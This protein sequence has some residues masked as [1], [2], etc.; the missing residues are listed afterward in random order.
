MRF[1][2]TDD[3]HD[4]MA[5]GTAVAVGF[6]ARYDALIAGGAGA[7]VV[8]GLALTRGG[9]RGR[10]ASLQWGRAATDA[11]V[12]LFP[13][14]VVAVVW[15]FTS[16]LITGT[17]FTQFSGAY[18][19]A[20]IIESVGGGATG[21]APE[22]LARILLLAP[23]LPVLVVTV[24]VLARR[25]RAPGLWPP[26]MLLGSVLAFQVVS[27][28]SGTTFGLLRFFIVAV[29]MAAVL[30]LLVPF[31]SGDVSS[32][33]PGRHPWSGGTQRPLYRPR[34]SALASLVLVVLGTTSTTVAMTEQRWA[35]QEYAL[36]A[37]TPLASGM[38][39]DDLAERRS[40]LRTFGVERRLAS[41]LDTRDLASG[42][43]LLDVTYGFPVPL[44][45]A[46]PDT[47]VVPSDPDFETS[48][49]D[50]YAH[51]VRYILAVPP[52]GRGLQDAVNRRYPTFYDNGAGV[53]TLDMEIANDGSGQPDF[54]L[55]RVRADP[56]A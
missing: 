16:W 46:A 34:T 24:L 18:G 20:A 27:A 17:A 22:A 51:G 6:L 14:S 5:A 13:V 45:S 11:V 49:D 2:R 15:F 10:A 19:N 38:D 28:A 9:W 3:V 31:T 42:S 43:V 26:L 56:E 30:A 25:R 8:T 37:L 44:F 40:V 52:E 41:Y 1:A 7:V 48:L 39:A 29:L 33:R 54:R 21:G 47:F 53:A 12:F 35:P 50:P 23:G 4:L 55:Y 32:R 36:A